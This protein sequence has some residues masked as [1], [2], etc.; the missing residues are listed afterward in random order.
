MS[1]TRQ[2]PSLPISWYGIDCCAVILLSLALSGVFFPVPLLL[3]PETAFPAGRCPGG[4]AAGLLFFFFAFFF[5]SRTACFSAL[6]ASFASL[7]A[8]FLSAF[9][10]SLCSFSSYFCALLRA[11]F[12]LRVSFR[13]GLRTPLWRSSA[14]YP[15]TI[16]SSCSLPL[17]GFLFISGTGSSSSPSSSSSQ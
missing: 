1:C 4:A 11:F 16:G 17:T 13:F 10:C 5:A 2:I 15:V 8:F 9:S 6:A 12:S 3:V 7:F 14:S